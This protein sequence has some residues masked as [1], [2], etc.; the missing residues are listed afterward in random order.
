MKY[1]NTKKGQILLFTLV[2]ITI[3]SIVTISIIVLSTRDVAEVVT[4]EKYDQ[5]YNAAES[6][7]SELLDRYGKNDVNPLP[8]ECTGAITPTNI[9]CVYLINDL[10]LNT[11]YQTK[12]QIANKKDI[13]G[14]KVDKDRSIEILLSGYTGTLNITWDT[15]V[16]ALDF[17][18]VYE[19]PSSPGQYKTVKD[20]YDTTNP[21]RLY[22]SLNTTTTFAYQTIPE[23]IS[24][25]V[26]TTKSNT[27]SSPLNSSIGLTNNDSP[28]YLQI[29]PRTTLTSS[30]LTIKPVDPNG[31]PFQVR[32]YFA[33]SI[34]PNDVNSPVA[35][36][37]AVILLN[38]QSNGIFGY[39]LLTDGI[40]EAKL[41][42]SP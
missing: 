8:A 40:L 18:F 31:Y 1:K 20:V 24:L 23:G 22:E 2:V 11:A 4:G 7:L 19:N 5:A 17:A 14:F 29:T 21:V 36:L 26:G 33:T 41:F 15:N 38:A 39:T 9:E 28:L 13:E 3:L 16:T 34:D 10:N 6:K 12:I 30:R 25:A 35:N 27:I 32:E 37:R 42:S